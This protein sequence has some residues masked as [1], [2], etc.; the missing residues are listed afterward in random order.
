M[1]IVLR[2]LGISVLARSDLADHPSTTLESFFLFHFCNLATFN[3]FVVVVG[4]PCARA[5][6]GATSALVPWRDGES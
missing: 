5:A 3:H 6:M 1:Y 2:L 4:R